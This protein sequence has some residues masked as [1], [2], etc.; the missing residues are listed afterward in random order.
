M[1]TAHVAAAISGVVPL[2]DT[3]TFSATVGG[4]PYDGVGPVGIT[5]YPVPTTF[6]YSSPG[7]AGFTAMDIAYLYSANQARVI[8][9]DTGLVSI[10][11]QGAPAPLDGA[12]AVRVDF[13]IA[14]AID[15]GGT[16][17]TSIP[18]AYP[19][20]F[21]QSATGMFNSFDVEIDYTS[22]TNGFLGTL[23]VHFAFAGG[24]GGSPY[25]IATGAPLSLPALDPL[26][27]LTLSGFF[28]LEADGFPGASTEI[29]VFGIPEPSSMVLLFVGCCGIVVLR[30][31]HEC[32]S[33]TPATKV[34]LHPRDGIR[35]HIPYP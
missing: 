10:A 7:S 25:Y 24:P 26:D 19:I 22:A 5:E 23:E 32:I 17:A 11:S 21:G 15:A 16:T 20:A 18:I 35:D 28:S 30:R 33:T 29:E 31:R 6:G 34:R 27:T 3:A 9:P 12:I 2:S 1:R 8:I 14:F 13:S 4:V